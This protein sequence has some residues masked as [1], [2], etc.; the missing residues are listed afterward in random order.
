MYDINIDSALKASS[1]IGG[2]VDIDYCDLWKMAGV[3]SGAD[4][5]V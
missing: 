1:L 2:V 5:G 4:L 3:M